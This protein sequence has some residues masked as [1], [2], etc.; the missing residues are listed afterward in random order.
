M[1]PAYFLIFIVVEV[2]LFAVQLIY[3]DSKADVDDYSVYQMYTHIFSFKRIYS[4]TELNYFGTILF[5]LFQT[6]ICPIA[7]AAYFIYWLCH[8]K[9]K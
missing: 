6:I 3:T 9:E 1:N 8:K 7:A 5:I 4:D 2:T